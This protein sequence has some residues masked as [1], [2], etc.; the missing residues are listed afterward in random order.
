MA[1]N[2][3]GMLVKSISEKVQQSKIII[4]S[5]ITKPN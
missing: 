1:M 2:R 4:A 3:V 5:S